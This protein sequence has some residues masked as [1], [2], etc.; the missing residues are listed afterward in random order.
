ML[1]INQLLMKWQ[2]G[3]VPSPYAVVKLLQQ[4]SNLKLHVS[5]RELAILELIDE[6]DLSN[7]L[8]TVE[9]YAESLNTL[10]AKVVQ[11]LMEECQSVKVKRVVVEG[12]SYNKKYKITVDREMVGNPF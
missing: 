10:R 1:K 12:G 4:E 8:D 6:L 2:T 3:E 7:S 5:S 9:N 11:E